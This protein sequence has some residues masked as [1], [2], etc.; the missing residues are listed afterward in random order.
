M[1]GLSSICSGIGILEED[2]NGNRI[3]YEKGEYC[4][5][6]VFTIVLFSWMPIS[7]FVCYFEDLI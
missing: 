1:D 4:S 2:E 6:T 5:G 7:I 3:G